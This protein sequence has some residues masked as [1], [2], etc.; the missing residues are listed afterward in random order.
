MEM[1][2]NMNQNNLLK[3]EIKQIKKNHIEGIT[4]RTLAKIVFHFIVGYPDFHNNKQ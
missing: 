4:P 2:E 1:K 3:N